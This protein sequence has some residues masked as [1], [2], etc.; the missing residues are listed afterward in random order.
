MTTRNNGGRRK[1]NYRRGS[2]SDQKKQDA[3]SGPMKSSAIVQARSPV[4]N[5]STN[6]TNPPLENSALAGSGGA[7]RL[8]GLTKHEKA[9]HLRK[10]SRAAKRLASI[11]TVEDGGQKP[12]ASYSRSPGQPLPSLSQALQKDDPLHDARHSPLPKDV[13]RKD[14][15]PICKER[16]R[17]N[18]RKGGGG[19]SRAFVP[20]CKKE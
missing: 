17:D 10:T 2:T 19:G 6:S 12:I 18:R 15:R 1:P 20:W 3:A 5:A 8:S 9:K 4:R 11:P 14:D 16:P 7:T 13:V